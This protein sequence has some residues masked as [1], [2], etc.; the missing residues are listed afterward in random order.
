MLQ[1]IDTA[2]TAVPATLANLSSLQYCY[3]D[4]SGMDAVAPLPAGPWLAS[5]RW[6]RAGVDTLASNTAVLQGA[7]A[8]E[9]LE[10]GEPYAMRFNWR[11]PAVTSFF[12]WLAQHPPLQRV[13]FGGENPGYGS[14]AASVFDSTAFARRLQLLAHRRPAL[15]L[16]R[17]PDARDPNAL[18]GT[19]LAR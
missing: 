19:L 5:L 18:L 17:M 4:V 1:L 7:T 11:P 9:R 16:V 14:E 6:L 12:K 13:S 15:Q 2:D 10:V 8:L 3:L